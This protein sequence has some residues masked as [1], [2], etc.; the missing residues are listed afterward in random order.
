LPGTRNLPNARKRAAGRVECDATLLSFNGVTCDLDDFKTVPS[1]KA[2]TTKELTATP[3]WGK[4]QAHKGWLKSV[5]D[6]PDNASEK[7]RT[8]V[9]SDGN[10]EKLNDILQDT[11]HLT[12]R[13]ASR[14]ELAMAATACMRIDGISDEQI[15][16]ALMWCPMPWN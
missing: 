5:D 9:A 15:A 1:K 14:S 4:V 6:L 16:A 7:L 10:L 13:Y 12:R 2:E 3:G 8:I 11:G